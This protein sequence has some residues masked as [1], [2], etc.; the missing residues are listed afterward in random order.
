[1]K[2]RSIYD[3]IKLDTIYLG[4]AI[5]SRCWILLKLEEEACL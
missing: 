4:N 3:Q 5:S 2:S 1:M